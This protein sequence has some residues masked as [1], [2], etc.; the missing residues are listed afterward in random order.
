MLPG[1]ENK[2]IKKAQGLVTSCDK[3]G[4][5][6]FNGVLF[7]STLTK[8]EQDVF[9]DSSVISGNVF[10]WPPHTLLWI[11]VLTSERLSKS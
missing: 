2:Q 6:C 1:H 8:E 11:P 4:K 7:H 5:A 10:L 9:S 3:A